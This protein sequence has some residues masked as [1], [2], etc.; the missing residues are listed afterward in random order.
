MGL[1][2][3]RVDRPTVEI[4]AIGLGISEAASANHETVGHPRA[5][6]IA[7]LGMLDPYVLEP[8]AGAC[9]TGEST[10]NRLIVADDRFTEDGEIVVF[11]IVPR[12]VEPRE[13]PSQS[14]MPH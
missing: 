4:D 9:G 5:D 11:A 13:K 2:D 14:R 10:L 7:G 1:L 6:P 12:A 3:D 8:R